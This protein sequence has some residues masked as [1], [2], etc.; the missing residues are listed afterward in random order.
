MYDIDEF[1]NNISSIIG[2]EYYDGT[3]LFT[4]RRRTNSEDES[5]IQKLR[6]D[7]R[8]KVREIENYIDRYISRQSDTWKSNIEE[9]NKKFLQWGIKTKNI[10]EEEPPRIIE[11]YKKN[12]RKIDVTDQKFRNEAIRHE[13]PAAFVIAYGGCQASHQRKI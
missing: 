13:M 7:I 12:N 4:E 2:L 1:F 5:M 3:N 9:W 8:G 11:D 6:Y 10:V